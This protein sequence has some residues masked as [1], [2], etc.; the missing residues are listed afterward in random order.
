MSCGAWCAKLLRARL[1][2]WQKL[3]LRLER[4]ILFDEA[5]SW[6]AEVQRSSDMAGDFFLAAIRS[7]GCCAGSLGWVPR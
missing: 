5:Y 4:V 1:E 7:I 6:R 3:G 2:S